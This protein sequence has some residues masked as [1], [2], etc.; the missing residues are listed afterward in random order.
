MWYKK[1]I[2][3]DTKKLKSPERLFDLL[4]R[5]L[6]VS[7]ILVVTNSIPITTEAF[8]DKASDIARGCEGLKHC[9]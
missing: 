7:T 9:Q 4:Y 3:D 2:P 1:K 6:R 8:I 5:L